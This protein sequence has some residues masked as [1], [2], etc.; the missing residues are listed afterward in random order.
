MYPA[1]SSIWTAC[2]P[3]RAGHDGESC[4]AFE[5][6]VITCWKSVSAQSASIGR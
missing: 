6:A 3:S 1:W 4:I 5:A 2:M